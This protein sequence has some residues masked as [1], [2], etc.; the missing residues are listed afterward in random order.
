MDRFLIQAGLGY[1]QREE[2]RQ[3]LHRFRADNPLERVQPIVHAEEIR[4][5]VTVCRTVFVHQAL[6]DYLLDLV[7]AT[8]TDSGLEL[9]VSPRGS[10]A[11]YRTVQAYAAIQGRS[12]VTPDDIQLLAAPVLRHRLIPG[13]R[14][15]PAWNLYCHASGWHCRQGTRSCGG[16]LGGACQPRRDTGNRRSGRR[17]RRGRGRSRRRIPPTAT[18]EAALDSGTP[19]SH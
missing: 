9:G 11:Y 16:E 7:A 12:F 18:I 17:Q 4:Q 2:E 14:Y 8:R 13:P 1:P 19:V 10:L 3:I 6:E 15:P 5:A